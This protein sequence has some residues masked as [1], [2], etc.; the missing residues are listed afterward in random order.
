M[1]VVEVVLK[2]KLRGETLLLVVVATVAEGAAKGAVA[3][4]CQEGNICIMLTVNQIGV[5]HIRIVSAAVHQ[6]TIGVCGETQQ[7]ATFPTLVH[8]TETGVHDITS[9]NI[10]PAVLQ[11]ILLHGGRVVPAVTVVIV[12][13]EVFF[14]MGQQLG[15]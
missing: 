7:L 5:L 14:P 15:T 4:R 9:T 1:L 3:N 10:L 12:V 8:H 2:Y 11:L 6:H 13:T